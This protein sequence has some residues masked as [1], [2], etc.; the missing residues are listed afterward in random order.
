[1]IKWLRKSLQLD[2]S[3]KASHLRAKAKISLTD[4]SHWPSDEEK[5]SLKVQDSVSRLSSINYFFVLVRPVSR[6]TSIWTKLSYQSLD[7][8]K[9]VPWLV[10]WKNPF[11]F[12]LSQK[13]WSR[14]V[15]QFYLVIYS[16]KMKILHIFAILGT[17]HIW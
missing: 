5:S 1:M 9:V 7:W 8:S 15:A 14:R 13:L 12:K 17:L 4:A 10:L 16:S 11:S 2:F 6:C 3:A